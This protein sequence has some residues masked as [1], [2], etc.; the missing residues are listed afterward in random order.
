MD[1]CPVTQT[2]KKQKKKQLGVAKADQLLHELYSSVEDD[3]QD[4]P[5]P[6]KTVVITYLG[7]RT[8]PLL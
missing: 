5:S 7:L 4:P 2:K 6:F 3:R 8:S 1:N